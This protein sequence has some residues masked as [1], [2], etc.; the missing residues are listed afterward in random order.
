MAQI[1]IKGHLKRGKEVIEVLEMLGGENKFNL[2][3][4][5]RDCFYRISE[6]GVIYGE[7][8]VTNPHSTKTFTL[9]NFEEKYPYK[10]GD[11]VI[12][13]H[14]SGVWEIIEMIWSKN[15]NI[16]SYGLKNGNRK[17]LAVVGE[18]KPYKENIKD[19]EE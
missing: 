6:D 5:H 19:N 15:L 3:N 10:L 9:E 8:M 12:L 11:K 13:N 14:Y 16:I 1:A 18:L 4:T 17:E 7:E 2:V